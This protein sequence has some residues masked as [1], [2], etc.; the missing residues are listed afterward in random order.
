[1]R[2]LMGD[3]LTP[4]FTWRLL[5]SAKEHLRLLL[6]PQVSLSV[7]RPTSPRSRTGLVGRPRPGGCARFAGRWRSAEAQEKRETG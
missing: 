5:G 1:M 6:A 4:R 7:R 3:R 2:F